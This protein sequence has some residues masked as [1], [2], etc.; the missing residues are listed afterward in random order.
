MGGG[1]ATKKTERY[2][3]FQIGTGFFG[4][5]II[6]L[7]FFFGFPFWQSLTGFTGSSY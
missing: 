6:F 2:R 1:G 4:F 5:F 3:K 7:S